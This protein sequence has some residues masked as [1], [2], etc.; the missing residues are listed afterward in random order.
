MVERLVLVL[1]DQL[2]HDVAALRDAD[3]SAD[4]VVMAE[5]TDETGYV[6]HHPKKIA[7]VLSAMRHFAQELEDDGWTV[8]YTRLDDP[9]ASRSIVGELMRRAEEHGTTDILATAP[10]EW[11]LREALENAPLSVRTLPDDRFIASQREFDDW[12][13]G[14]KSLRM[15]YFYREMRRKTGLLMEDGEPAGGKWNYDHENRKPADRDLFRSEP[16]QFTPDDVTEDVLALVE[17]RFG[18][19]FGT[20]RPFTFAVT[21]AQALRAL[22]HF[23][24][25]QLPE[26]GDYQDAMLCDDR[27]LNHSLLSPYINLGLLSPLEVCERVAEEWKADRV[28]INSAEG[29]IRQIIG[30]REY[31]RGLYFHEGPDYPTRNV[32]DHDRDLPWMYW[33]GETRM[34]CVAHAVGQTRDEAYAHHIQR[35]MV[36]GNFALLAGIDPRQVHEWYLAV[37][38]DAYEWV[39]APNTVG[40]SQWADGGIIASKPYVSSGN[41]IDRMSDYCASCAY[42]VKDKTGEDAC[43]FNLLYWH[44]LDRHRKRFEKNPRMAQMFATWDRMD[45]ERRRDV[46]KGARRILD[47]LDAGEIV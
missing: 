21:R 5:V 34:N 41:Y 26:F 11:R 15:E 42:K 6:P 43:P 12:A 38:V 24:K 7:L 27:F 22:D 25:R 36:T 46:L 33:G 30:W 4:V 3:K 47:R 40:M 17:D 39:E 37:Y 44:F 31:V 32:L 1:G 23:A 16:M 2:S 10:G 29:Y 28:P 20:L 35:L 13:D 19:N 8:A 18:D 45:A 14:R 9:D